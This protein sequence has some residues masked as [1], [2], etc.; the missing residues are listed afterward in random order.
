M[1]KELTPEVIN[2]LKSKIKFAVHKFGFELELEDI[3]QEIFCKIVEGHHQ[4]STMEQA[5]IDYI[6]KH[7]LNRK[8]TKH[9]EEKKNLNLKVLDIEKC[10]WVQDM[11][12]ID[13]DIMNDCIKHLVGQER[14]VFLLMHKWGLSQEEISLV[15]GVT[16]V[17]IHQIHKNAIK[18]L[19]VKFYPTANEATIP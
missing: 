9:Y 5:V 8:G 7:Y 1:K 4:K 2:K 11:H 17:R 12:I 14:I 15:F 16:P 19:N 18:Q 6:R 13:N 3:T 10:Y